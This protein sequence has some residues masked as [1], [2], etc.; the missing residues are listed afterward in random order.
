M[1]FGGGE[2]E[3]AGHEVVEQ[4]GERF[5]GIAQARSGSARE[6]AADEVQLLAGRVE[7]RC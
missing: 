1:A 4:S 7:M 3:I 5:H 6:H 2:I